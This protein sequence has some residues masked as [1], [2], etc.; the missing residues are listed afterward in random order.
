VKNEL[1]EQDQGLR[2]IAD[3]L[4]QRAAQ[5]P[6]AVALLC[7]ERSTTMAELDQRASQVAHGLI[8][9]LPGEQDRAGVLDTNSDTFFELLFGAAK[10]NRILVPINHR[11][12][13]AEMIVV[14]LDAGVEMLFVGAD[15]LG[16]AE[17]LRAACPRVRRI[18]TLGG[19]RAGWDDYASWRDRQPSHDPGVA[20]GSG[21]VILI[22]YTSGTTGRPKGAQLTHQSLL[23]NAPLLLEER[24]SSPETDVGLVCLPLF[25]VSGSLWAMSCLYASVRMVI[26]RRGTPVD[27]LSA[28]AVHRITKAL[29]VPSLIHM[30]L[31]ELDR[32]PYDTSSLEFV[33]YGASPIAVPLLR[34]ALARLG[35]DLGQVYGLT[36][37]AG[38]IT[39]LRPEDHTLD[40]PARLQ[41]CGRPLRHVEV[42]V[43]DEQG[44]DVVGPGH[45]GEIICRSRQ[46]MKGYWHNTEATAAVLRDDW[47]HTGDAGYFDDDGYLYIHDRIKDLI[48]SGGENIYP[49]EVERALLRHPAVVDVAVI[50]VPDMSWGEAVKAFVVKRPDAEAT[51]DELIAFCRQSI[52]A[53]KTPKSIEFVEA[54]KRNAAGKVLKHELREPYWV[55]R[56]RRVN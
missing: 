55:G 14:V 8:H 17:A 16:A 10:A 39:Y 15:F 36:E 48:I 47:L 7:E 19:S 41:S 12:A 35:C 28:I 49:A 9:D 51:A 50:A 11:L 4:R 46:N 54:L 34:R 1:S 37:T 31:D 25:H 27:V 20:A 44:T 32:Q 40:N 3:L 22:G 42:R 52:A 29:L 18:I 38:A 26:L 33:L 53:F 30:L 5:M 24:G 2:N 13:P 6:G 23:A 21:D 43:V 56:S 45:I